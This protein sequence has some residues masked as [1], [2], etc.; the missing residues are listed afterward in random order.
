MLRWI[1]ASRWRGRPAGAARAACVLPL[2]LVLAGCGGG[3]YL[4]DNFDDDDPPEVVLIVS[5]DIAEAGQEVRLRASA[6]DDSGI[7]EVV[8]FRVDGAVSTRLQSDE[9]A[10][11]E[12]NTELPDDAT[13]PV[14][15]FAR[16]I[17]NDGESRD[18]DLFS[19]TVDR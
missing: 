9:T 5:P 1:R 7:D 19:V 6:S 17:D 14:Q 8:F 16:A 2:A 11:Y 13:E 18:S 15:F 4:G 12:L 10:P 3:F